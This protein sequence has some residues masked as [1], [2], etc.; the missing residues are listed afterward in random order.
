MQLHQLCIGL[1]I[2]LKMHTYT[3]PVV[4]MVISPLLRS[5]F[6]QEILMLLRKRGPS[7]EGVFRKPGNSKNMK[8]IREQLNSGLEVDME[9]QPVV[10]L[11]ALLKVCTHILLLLLLLLQPSLPQPQLP[12]SYILQLQQKTYSNLLH[13]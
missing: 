9:S 1:V 8:D 6:H 12:V 11:V 13:E 2:A 5:S 7:T 10:M 3:K 4:A